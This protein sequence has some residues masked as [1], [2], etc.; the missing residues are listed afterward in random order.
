MDKPLLMGGFDVF[1]I[2]KGLGNKISSPVLSGIK[3]SWKYEK[4]YLYITVYF[5]GNQL[6]T[7]VK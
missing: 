5:K 2:K 6:D 4:D 7:R 3:N 1:K